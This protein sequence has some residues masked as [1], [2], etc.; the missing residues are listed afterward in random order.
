MGDSSIAIWNKDRVVL[1]IALG[2]WVTNIAFLCQG[3]S[4]CLSLPP[5]YR[6]RI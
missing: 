3:E 6:L 4:E 5:S 2:V 1:V